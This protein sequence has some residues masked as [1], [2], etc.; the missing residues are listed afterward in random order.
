MKKPKSERELIE[1]L[2]KITDEALRHMPGAPSGYRAIVRKD[3]VL[4]FVMKTAESTHDHWSLASLREALREILVATRW[5]LEEES[6][7]RANTLMTD[8]GRAIF[9]KIIGV[10]DTGDAVEMMSRHLE[11]LEKAAKRFKS[12]DDPPTEKEPA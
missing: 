6:Q 12:D 1:L 11:S 9:A 4:G 3:V 7:D 5:I 10:E 2:D 8:D